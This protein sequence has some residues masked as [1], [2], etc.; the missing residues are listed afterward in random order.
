MNQATFLVLFQVVGILKQTEGQLTGGSIQTFQKETKITNGS[1]A[2][3]G[4][5]PYQVAL[6]RDNILHCGGSFV[7]ANGQHWVITAAHCVEQD[8]NPENYFVVAGQINENNFNSPGQVRNV[9]QIVIHENFAHNVG[10]FND[11]AILAISS[12]FEIDSFVSPI[13]LPRKKERIGKYGLVSGWAGSRPG[14]FDGKT[15]ICAGVRKGACMGDS[16]GPLVDTKRKFLA[17][18]VSA[19]NG[20]CTGPKRN[21]VY[22]RVSA[23]VSWIEEHA[24]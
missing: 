23:F 12:P 16:G 14:V 15:M 8:D 6:Y 5:I 11:I 13:R 22:T 19:G 24:K 21:G 9:N 10:I 4:E 20:G 18:I 17:G 2:K 1:P 3:P 7:I